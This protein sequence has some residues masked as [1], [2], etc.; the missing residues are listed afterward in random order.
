MSAAHADGR[1]ELRFGRY[2]VTVGKAGKL[3]FPG[4]GFTKLD[5][6]EH[7]RR[8]ASAMLPHIAG[9]PV[10]LQR[11][12]DGIG[13]GGFFQKQASGH[14][15]EWIERVRMPKAGGTVDH[16]VVRRAAD[17]A[18]LVDQGTITF[19]GALSP[20]AHLD[21]PDR[22]VFDLDPSVDDFEAVR[23]G[24]RILRE[25]LDDLDLVPY[26]MTTGSRGLHVVVPVAGTE[27][28]DEIEP[29]AE[30]VA[31]AVVTREPD[32]YTV[33]HRKA[34]RGD[35]VLVDWFRNAYAQ[36]AVSPWSLRPRPGAPVAVPIPWGELDDPALS[37]RRY[38][39]GDVEAL[40]EDRPDPWAGMARRARSTAKARRR[41][42]RTSG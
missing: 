10:T 23:D 38:R 7:Y 11:F 15:P 41:L 26:L 1:P 31:Q 19:H 6:V 22:L 12:P 36:T 32:R 14:F 8:V 2:T 25:L 39:I 24:A 33:A 9:R 34:R 20:A 28:F 18:Y 3:L 21:R 27:T 17:L 40:V 42:G 30:G 16:V 37:G 29:L 13:A 35:R 4:D 5:I